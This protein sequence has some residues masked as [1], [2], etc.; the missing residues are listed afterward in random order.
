MNLGK[1]KNDRKLRL[2][3]LLLAVA[4]LLTSSPSY[5][6]TKYGTIGGRTFYYTLSGTKKVRIE[7]IGKKIG[8]KDVA[9]KWMK[10]L[11]QLTVETVAGKYAIPFSVVKSLLEASKR[12]VMISTK[13]YSSYVFQMNYKTRTIFAYTN[14]QKT[15]KRTALQ[16]EKGTVDIF[17]VW[18][19]V[20]SGYK[21][22]SYEKKLASNKTIKTDGYDNKTSNLKTCRTYYNHRASVVKRLVTKIVVSDRYA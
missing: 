4:M 7:K 10:G 2:C 22:S 16:D 3:A 5:A 18:H 13:A 1:R 17:F 14:P 12:N 15:K 19:P 6:A 8:S 9:K 11:A 20:G 21:K